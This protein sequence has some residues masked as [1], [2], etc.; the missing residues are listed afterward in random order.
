[1]KKQHYVWIKDFSRLMFAKVNKHDH[2]LNFCYNCL[3]HFSSEKI[4][5][6]HKDSGCYDNPC[7]KVVLPEPNTEDCFISYKET[8]MK[9]QLKVPFIIY[10]DFEALLKEMI[11]NNQYQQHD[12]CSY[13]YKL[14]SVYEGLSK[15]YKSYRGP[16]TINQ[17]SG[18]SFR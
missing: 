9:K 6:K 5:K 13:G 16:N 1:M 8:M 3:N 4:L 2:K 12:A 7:A 11:S 14:V 15:E 18:K 10:A 17:F